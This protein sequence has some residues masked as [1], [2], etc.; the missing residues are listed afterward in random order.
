MIRPAAALT[1]LLAIGA[2]A[3]GSPSP[4]R[5]AASW[6]DLTRR[7]A[8]SH[9]YIARN[10]VLGAEP[11]L[12]VFP[13][14]ARPALPLLGSTYFLIVPG[15][16]QGVHLYYAPTPKTTAAVERLVAALRAARYTEMPDSGYPNGFVGDDRPERTWCP[17]D[18]R[19]PQIRLAVD[20]VDGVPA[21]DLEFA[22]DAGDTTCGRDEV[23]AAAAGAQ[24]PALAGIP[25]L[26]IYAGRRGTE[27]R[28]ASLESTAVIRT[29][30][31]PADALA[32]LAE[33]FTANGWSAR[34][35]VADGT[36]LV[37][38][39]SRTD[40]LRRWNA[41]LVF[42]PRAGSRT[43]YDAALDVTSDLL[44]AGR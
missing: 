14:G 20:T 36:T 9:P 25:G 1:A 23:D 21:L 6:A 41:L 8:A 42:E 12:F 35:P 19:D 40:R 16:P 43:L 11:P 24:L 38:H 10:V 13:L 4:A 5:A 29:S 27:S 7:I 33:R 32:K 26:Q 3:A 28:E 34:P 30:L 31:S 39:F 18:L 2:L 22:S 17:A 44:G 15:A 37:Q